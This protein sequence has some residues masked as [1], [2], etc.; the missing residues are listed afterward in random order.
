[1]DRC[2]V[3]I[4]VIQLLEPSFAYVSVHA[5]VGRMRMQ[6]PWDSVDT[7]SFMDGNIFFASEYF[8]ASRVLQWLINAAYKCLHM[9]LS[10]KHII[11][12]FEC[13]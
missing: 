4:Y 11:G 3:V 9:C 8:I 12:Y 10:M 2:D 6:I 5:S 1:M 7:L 13:Y